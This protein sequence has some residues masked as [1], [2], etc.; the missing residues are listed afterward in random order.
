MRGKDVGRKGENRENKREREGGGEKKEKGAE[1]KRR[2]NKS[3]VWNKNVRTVVGSR[4]ESQIPQR[5]IK[6]GS[7]ETTKTGTDERNER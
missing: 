1:P 4:R 7:N 3:R 6:V 5:A 2:E